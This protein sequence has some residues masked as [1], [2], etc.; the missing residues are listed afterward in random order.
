[1]PFDKHPVMTVDRDADTNWSCYTERR[2]ESILL[3]ILV[4]RP[5]GSSEVDAA[6]TS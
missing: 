4:Q 2:D 1:M 3:T 6:E 5:M